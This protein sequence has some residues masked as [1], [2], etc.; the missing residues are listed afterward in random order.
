[1]R[2]S[3]VYYAQQTIDSIT[4]TDIYNGRAIQYFNEQ[5]NKQNV[6]STI[7]IIAKPKYFK[8]LTLRPSDYQ[9]IGEGIAYQLIRIKIQTILN[10]KVLIK[11]SS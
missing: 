11:Q 6:S 4:E 1:M 7:L 2:P 3:M 10:K 5:A 8:Q 9:V